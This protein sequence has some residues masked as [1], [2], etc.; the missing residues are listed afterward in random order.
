MN[1]TRAAQC[2]GFLLPFFYVA[3]LPGQKPAEA[4][5]PDL[6]QLMS[7]VA[8]HQKQLE[9]VREN[10]TYTA[11]TTTQDLDANGQ[12]KKTETAEME[13]FFVHG[14]MI[15]RKI[16]K[17]GRPLDEQEQQK[18]TERVTRFVE[19]AEKPKTEKKEED[20]LSLVKLL[21]IVE[22]SRPQRENFRGRATIVCDFAGRKDAKAHGLSE[23]VFKKLRGT[24]WID[25]A[26]HEVTRLEAT[27]FD[28]FHIGG[29]LLVNIAK[30][31]H[32]SFDQAKINGE[33]WLPID[34]E[35]TLDARLMIFKG[36]R[37]HI[38]EQDSNYQ[39]FHA[40]AQQSKDV[41]VVVEKK[42]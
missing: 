21:D 9:K 41:K 31:T 30:G 3:L 23:D 33:I 37:Q 27:F 7:E 18:E 26:D 15:A 14:Q 17:D 25:E 5:L 40:E 13:I 11:Q 28:N 12:V 39:R 19:K 35:G 34:S 4:P 24:V 36:I 1:T 38:V 16:K 8:E 29:G 32:L 10:Y 20:E 42:Q 22:A 6:R 2:A